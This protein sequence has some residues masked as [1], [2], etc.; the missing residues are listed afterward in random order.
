MGQTILEFDCHTAS[1][2]C[3]SSIE[4]MAAYFHEKTPSFS[5]LTR[6]LYDLVDAAPED[7]FVFTSS[8]AEAVG[9]AIWSAF[10]EVS[11]KEGKT[12]FITS[13]IE[14]AP[15]LQMLQR[16]EQFGCL[17]KI[18][19]I[20][21]MGRVDV[22]AL[23][24]LITPRTALISLS[25]A[26]G[27][28]GVIQPVEEIGRLAKQRGVFF[29]LDV[30]YA[31]GK[32]YFSFSGSNADY[33]TFAGERIHSVKGSGAL[34]AKKGRPLVPFILGRGSI[35]VPSL[36]ALSAAAQ[37]TGLSL[38]AMGLEGARLRSLFETE[39]LS[40]IPDAKVLYHETPRL[41]NTTA[42]SF[43]RVHAEALRFYIGRR[44]IY[45]NEEGNYCQHLAPLL[46][47]SGIEGES[48]LSFSFSRMTT[49]EEIL[50]GAERIGET[51]QALRKLTEDLF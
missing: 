20:D 5:P 9:Q 23:A 3:Q 49:Q 39:L 38:D 13:C 18:A 27:L 43:P 45:P 32:T 4:R 16:C 30:S 10:S 1:R 42:I 46:A 51:V 28:T 2:P 21:K 22:E 34:F 44:G 29:H 7:A 12:Q 41:P 48:A 31:I 24:A 40:R 19:P 11:R 50:Q 35:D 26:Q 8:G 14:D 25:A 37:L 15:T 17:V 36:A 6:P 47:A 33:L